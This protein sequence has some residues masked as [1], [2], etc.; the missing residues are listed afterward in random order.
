MGGFTS[1][2]K[3]IWCYYGVIM[4]GKASYKHRPSTCT[5]E[6]PRMTL[7]FADREEHKIVLDAAAAEDLS[8]NAWVKRIILR[9]ARD[10]QRKQNQEASR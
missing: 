1:I 3:I 9:A 8:V 7:R 5:E 2:S 6:T 4:V 10:T